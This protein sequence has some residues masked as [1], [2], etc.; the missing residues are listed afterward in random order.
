[1]IGIV[2]MPGSGKSEFVNIALTLGYRFISM[3]DIV[4]EETVRKGYP[5][6]ESG[7]VAQKLR[8]E[9]GL[10][11]IA[12]LTLDKIRKIHDNKFLIE[13]IRGIKEIERFR[14]EM[15]FFNWYTLFA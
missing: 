5:L 15:D 3:G 12:I 10:D 4:R 13:G 8:D 6:E 2:G 11:I 1:M 14:M 7:K 9:N